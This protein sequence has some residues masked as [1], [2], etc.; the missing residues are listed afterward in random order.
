MREVVPRDLVSDAKVSGAEGKAASFIDQPRAVK[1][2][3]L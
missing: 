2:L 3:D 1:Q